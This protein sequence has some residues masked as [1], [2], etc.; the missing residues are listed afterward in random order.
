[1]GKLISNPGAVLRFNNV[2]SLLSCVLAYISGQ[3]VVDIYNGLIQSMNLSIAS[4]WAT[5]RLDGK[6]V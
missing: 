3:S 4:H 2:D 1:M 5:L 6:S